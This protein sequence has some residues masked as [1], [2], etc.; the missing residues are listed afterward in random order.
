[1]ST[2][3]RVIGP[4]SDE[5]TNGARL[6]YR[7]YQYCNHATSTYQNVTMPLVHANAVTILLVHVNTVTILIVHVDTVTMPIVHAI[8]VTMLLVHASTVTLSL[9][10][11]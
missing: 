10:H 9:I 3:R 4:T 11:I 5:L 6:V 1:M 8:T 7:N 2:D